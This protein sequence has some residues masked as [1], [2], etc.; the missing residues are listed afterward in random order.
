MADDLPPDEDDSNLLGDQDF[1]AAFGEDL[2]Q[3][4]KLETW[5]SGVDP[6]E[7]MARFQRE[8]STAVQR[9]DRVRALIREKLLPRIAGRK[10]GPAEAGVFRALPGELSTIHEGLL[11]PGNVIAVLGTAVS[12][13]S[14]PLSIT[15]IGVAAVGYHGSAGTFSQNLFRKELAAKDTNSLQEAVDCIANRHNT[16]AAIHREILSRLAQRGIRTYAERAVLV[17]KVTAE[18]RIGHGNPFAHELLTGS[19]HVGLLKASL[20][21]L[22]RLV[23]VQQKFVFVSNA[24]PEQGL[25]TLGLA[26]DAGEYIVFENLERQTKNLFRSW[27]ETDPR[28]PLTRRF[29]HTICPDVLLGVF[30]VS[31]RTAPRLFYAHREHVHMAARV[32]MADSIVR[33]E[34]SYPLLLDVAELTCRSKF[35]E[36]GFEGFVQDAYA[37][38]GAHLQYLLERESRR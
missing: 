8:I 37:Q 7:I 16:K 29:V 28:L 32:A 14:L 26:L 19:G 2:A 9:E 34:K 4:L 15:Q 36:D 20:Q 18:W 21:V 10:H 30:R 3:T 25:M 5:S 1:K 13:Q 11:F 35:G 33:V 31:N 38:A 17:D 27:K 12:H 23:R 22:E 24:Q 6:K